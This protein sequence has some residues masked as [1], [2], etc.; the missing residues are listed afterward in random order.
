MYIKDALREGKRPHEQYLRTLQTF[1]YYIQSS[2]LHRVCCFVYWMLHS[3][4][5]PNTKI[6][7]ES[8]WC[9]HASH[10]GGRVWFFLYS[11]CSLLKQYCSLIKYQKWKCYSPRELGYI[12]SRNKNWLYYKTDWI[13]MDMTYNHIV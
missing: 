12:F 10:G 9:Y 13:Y 1:L 11:T 5:Y 3:Q 6:V 2:R 8:V 4:T 7:L